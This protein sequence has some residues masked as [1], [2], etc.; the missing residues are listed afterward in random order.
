LTPNNLLKQL[1]D[2]EAKLND[3]SFDGQSAADLRKLKIYFQLFKSELEEKLNRAQIT[4]VSGLDEILPIQEADKNSKIP[5]MSRPS[6]KDKDKLLIAHV[7]HELRMPL[8]GIVGFTDLLK[9]SKLTK[10]QLM[11]VNAID[12][13]SNLLMDITGELTEYSVL[14]SGLEEYEYLD[15]NFHS[16]I[17]DVVYLCDT[18][19][20]DKHVTLKVAIDKNIPKTLSG[21]PSKLSQV[22]L[23]LIGN[24]IKF[25][26]TGSI[27][28]EVVLLEKAKDAYLLEFEVKDTGIG[29]EE[30]KVK[31]IFDSFT[32][33]ARDT[34]KHYG[35]FGLGLNI[36]KQIIENQGGAITVSSTLGVGTSF[37][38]MLPFHKGQNII[39]ESQKHKIKPK[40]A[41]ITSIVGMRILVFED[42]ELNQKLIKEQLKGFKCTPYVTSNASYGLKVLEGKAIDMVLMDVRMPETNGLLLTKHI[43]AH[44]DE[45]I[46]QVPIVA[47]TADTS[48]INNKKYSLMLLTQL[49]PAPM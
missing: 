6:I 33:G 46:R 32:Q 36:V 27:H 17:H 12:S 18:L 13:A 30:D 49:I 39:S 47:L 37:K 16:I 8:N 43:R 48:I 38:F 15:F 29:I 44:R 26:E 20:V 19:I 2:L 22:L 5:E 41:K 10:E 45:K 31:D 14:S 25:V 1:A 40:Q 23:N 28:L 9:E 24:A 4:Q 35:G 42:D 11:Y 34:Q 7:S 3:F 21:D